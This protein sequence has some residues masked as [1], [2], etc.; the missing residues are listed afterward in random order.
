MEN[1]AFEFIAHLQPL[2]PVALTNL[3]HPLSYPCFSQTHF[4][5]KIVKI[6]E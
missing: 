5:V 6:Y 2:F 4:L 1:L 3:S